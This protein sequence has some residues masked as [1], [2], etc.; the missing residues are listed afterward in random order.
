MTLTLVHPVWFLSC[1]TTKGGYK[2]CCLGRHRVGKKPIVRGLSHSSGLAAIRANT[3][4]SLKDASS[5]SL[6]HEH[7]AMPGMNGR[8]LAEAA[9]R[10]MPNLKVLYMTGYSRNAIV[11]HGR[12]DTG[13][14]LIQKPFSQSALARRVKGMLVEAA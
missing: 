5:P 14:A 11:H 8:E 12:L 6:R 3:S 7:S 2:S 9:L 1:T 13:V 4:A 10:R